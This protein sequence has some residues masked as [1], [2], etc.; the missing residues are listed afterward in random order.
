[1]AADCVIE[2]RM[3]WWLPM[4]LTCILW[5]IKFTGPEPNLRRVEFWIGRG[6]YCKSLEAA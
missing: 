3:R 4:Y 5:I 2:I 1:M 6:V